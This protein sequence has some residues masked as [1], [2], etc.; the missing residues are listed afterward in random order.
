[1]KW[2]KRDPDAFKG[3]TLGLSLEE[4]GA[5]T[6]LLD[7]IY[8]RDGNVP[9]DIRYLCRLW[10]CDPRVAR[11]IRARLLELKKLEN[12]GQLLTNLRATYELSSP[13]VTPY[14][15]AKTQRNQQN[16]PTHLESRIKK[17]EERAHARATPPRNFK[18]INGGRSHA[19]QHSVCAAID[20]L[21]AQG[22]QELDSGTIET[23]YVCV[24]ER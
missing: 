6:L 14:L 24:P 4:I 12:S 18:T 11:R 22:A 17:K 20:R 1:M 13:D 2:Y 9:D 23:D 15:K 21:L 19:E 7:D 16:G 3:G 5:Y 10:R 8:A